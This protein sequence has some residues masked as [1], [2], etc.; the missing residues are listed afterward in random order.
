M[1]RV[2]RSKRSSE[3]RVKIAQFLLNSSWFREMR[4]IVSHLAE[5]SPPHNLLKVSLTLQINF[6]HLNQ[7]QR[8]LVESVSE[9][10][11]ARFFLSLEDLP[12]RRKHRDIWL[13]VDLP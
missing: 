3:I 6:K 11:K 7:F 10:K 5:C 12:I 8:Y 4:A 9:L 13:E 2:F 1:K